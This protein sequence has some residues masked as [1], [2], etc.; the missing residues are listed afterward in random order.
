MST[1][2]RKSALFLSI[3]LTALMSCSVVKA[4]VLKGNVTEQGKA[5]GGG[6]RL[7]RQ[8]I[9]A[10]GDPFGAGAPKDMPMVDADTMLDAPKG[11]FNID[12]PKSPPKQ[13]KGFSL[14]GEKDDFAG[15]PGQP[16]VGMNGQPGQASPD[17]FGGSQ[18]PPARTNPASSQP[19]GGNPNLQKEDPES[20]LGW[21]EWHHRVAQAIFQRWNP[22]V[23][24]A[25][26]M[27]PSPRYSYVSYTVTR[28]GHIRDVQVLKKDGNVMYNALIVQIIKSFDGDLGTLQFPAGS[29]RQS[30]ENFGEFDQNQHSHPTEAFR[31]VRGDK[32]HFK[33]RP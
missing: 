4:D 25:F 23:V 2:P 21:D 28:D 20:D 14:K 16:M 24:N 30:I 1:V 8:D 10:L 18:Q 33:G 15:S 32:E 17:Q 12:I 19:G 26:R 31:Y 27:D 6:A 29:H 7:N 3:A 22:M 13:K 5:G 9:D 11:A